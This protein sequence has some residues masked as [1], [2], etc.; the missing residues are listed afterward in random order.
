MTF[1]QQLL[2]NKDDKMDKKIKKIQ[3]VTKDL[4]KKE[5][6]LLRLDKKH[7]KKLAKCDARMKKK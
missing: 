4:E 2:P 1:G 3:K 6:E 7:D 5:S